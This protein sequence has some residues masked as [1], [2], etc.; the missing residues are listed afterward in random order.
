MSNDKLNKEKQKIEKQLN[1][2]ENEL[3]RLNN[4][5][6]EIKKELNENKNKLDTLNNIHQQEMAKKLMK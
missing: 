3:N 1:E 2:Y 6:Q 4:E 5:K